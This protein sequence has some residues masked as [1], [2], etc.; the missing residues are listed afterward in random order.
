MRLLIR[1]QSARDVNPIQQQNR[2]LKFF[3]SNSPSQPIETA[4]T[5]E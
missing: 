5:A 3:P 1:G 2:D 4:I